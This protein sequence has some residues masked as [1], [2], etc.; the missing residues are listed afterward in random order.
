MRHAVGCSLISEQ[1]P[2]APRVGHDPK[3]VGYHDRVGEW[4][5]EP[6]SALPRRGNARVH[7]FTRSTISSRSYSAKVAS[8]FSISSP[9]A[10][11]G[12]IPSEVDLRYT[13]RSRSRFTVFCLGSG[14]DVSENITLLHSGID[15]RVELQLRVLTRLTH[16]RIP[17]LSQ[18]AHFASEAPSQ[19]P[20]ETIRGD[21]SFQDTRRTGRPPVPSILIDTTSLSRKTVAFQDAMAQLVLP[22]PLAGAD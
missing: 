14:R 2:L 1:V 7:A 21:T 16:T 6:G 22:V 10:V 9:D 5:A 4:L 12:S 11:V 15:K 13:P 8:M 17:K 3:F 20:S 18:S 19:H